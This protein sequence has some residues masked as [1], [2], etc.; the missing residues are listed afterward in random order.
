MGII[1]HSGSSL[2]IH[3]PQR[4]KRVPTN[5]ATHIDHEEVLLKSD[6]VPCMKPF[7][8]QYEKPQCK[9]DIC[10]SKKVGGRQ[11]FVDPPLW[12]YV[13]TGEVISFAIVYA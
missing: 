11:M 12:W 13:D 8:Q 3:N 2:P 10:K 5:G 4:G 9:S 7:Q 6:I 1:S